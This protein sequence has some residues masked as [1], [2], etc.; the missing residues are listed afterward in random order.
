MLAKTRLYCS[1]C[2]KSQRDVKKLIANQTDDSYIC[3]ECVRQC[4]AILAETNKPIEK[5]ALLPSPRLIKEFLDQYVIGQDNAKEVIAVAIYNHYKRLDHP[6][7]D[8]VEIEK[9]NILLHGPTGVGKTLLI[10]SIARMLDVPL[11]MA[12]ATALTEAGYV[13]DD[14]ENV[15]GRLL[16]NAGN[17]V[18][19]AERGIVFLDEIDKKAKRDGHGTAYRDVAGEGVQQ[20][21]LMLL[22]GNDIMVPT[23]S[24]RSPNAD[25][26]KVNT[27]NILF[28]LGGAFIGLDRIAEQNGIPTIGFGR[29]AQAC[30]SRRIEPEH[31]IRY[32]LI[33]E[34]VGRLPIVTGF[35]DLDE[36]QLVRILTEPRNAIVKQYTK[37]FALD[38]IELEFDQD[39]LLE[40]AKL[41][42]ARK[43]NGRALR[44]VLESCL[45]RTQFDL[46]DLRAQGVERIIVRAAT[47]TEGRQP[48]VIYAAV[49]RKMRG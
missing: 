6:I 46:P 25:M 11:A 48:D 19:R 10:Q 8:G 39:A 13:G 4:T 27:R 2:T 24:R 9:S 49:R 16:Q 43:T 36:Q 30:L 38:G 20:A 37:M 22:E 23:G 1:F 33:P 35:D 41:A 26:V 47:V 31:L 44:G 34:L 28:I 40:V 12:D 14:V 5:K 29:G 32:G 42:R 17:D 21:L 15:I 3:E 18:K 7:I 45:L